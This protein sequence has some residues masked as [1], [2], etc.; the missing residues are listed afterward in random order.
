MMKRQLVAAA[1][2][3][4]GVIAVP[5]A[6][7]SLA[8]VARQ[9]EARRKNP[10]A[11]KAVRS[12]SNADLAASEIDPLPPAVPAAPATAAAGCVESTSQ[13]KCVPAEQ[14]VT[15]SES[16]VNHLDPQVKTSE[17]TVRDRATRIRERLLKAQQEFDA[18][19]ATADDASRSAG[20]RAAAARI[21]SQREKLVAGIESQWRALE[22]LVADEGLPQEWL[23]P[24]PLLSTRSPQ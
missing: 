10:A 8:E 18:L 24:T 19:S 17:A 2:I 7:Q 14:V 11:K 3:V 13:G 6:A 4:C 5:A 20:E 22:K 16:T 23:A 21:A 15:K 12:F 1:V 9:E